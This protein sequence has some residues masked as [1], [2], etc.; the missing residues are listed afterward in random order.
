MAGGRPTKYTNELGI[1]ICAEISCSSKSLRTICKELGLSVQSVLN[2]LNEHELFLAQYAR[3]KEE[4]ADMLAE[5]ILEIADKENRTVIE[6]SN[7]EGS[8]ITEQDN[9]Q[10]SRLQIDA[11]KWIASKLKPKKWGEKMDITTDG[12]KITSFNVG[13]KKPDDGE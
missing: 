11:R 4:Q 6:Y 12:E 3:A 2:W 1:K 5:E 7:S 13:F 9:V 8:G 10:R